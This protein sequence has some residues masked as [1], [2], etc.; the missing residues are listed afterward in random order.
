L[1][2]PVSG[3]EPAAST[4]PPASPPVAD[5]PGASFF[6]I[7]GR[8]APAL[9]VVGWL[10]SILGAGVIAIAVMADRGLASTIV[11][12]AGLV[13]LS[14][15][16]VAAAGSQGIE[17]RARGMAGYAGPSPLLVFAASIPVSILAIV[18]LALPLVAIGVDV[19]GPLGA[20]L[21]VAIQAA[22]YVGLVRLLVVDT[23]ALDWWAMGIGWLN[24]AAVAEM[25]GGALWAIPVYVLAI[26]VS[27]ILLM[28]FPVT[29][30]SVLPPTGSAPGFALSLIAGVVVAPFGEELLFRS[31][32]TTAWVR[33]I[34]V[35]G[36]LARGAVVFA[37]AHILTISGTSAE[38]GIQLAIVGFLTR[39]PIGLALGMVFIRRHTIWS[40]FG[41]HAAYNLIILVIAEVASRS[42]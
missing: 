12:L 32:A 7:E 27:S 8:Q 3:P 41:L 35:R 31:F 34:G 13:S 11:M 39:L 16:L 15:G 37:V 26:L 28:F 24:L 33:G 38:E 10:A 2:T 25:A 6:S 1:T 17:R 14:V 19:D 23:G 21:S 5:R 40:S 9:F 4:D 20:L 30:E 29:P 36:G 22:V 42:I 18:V